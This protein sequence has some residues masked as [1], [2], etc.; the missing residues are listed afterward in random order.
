MYTIAPAGS[1]PKPTTAL[2]PACGPRGAAVRRAKCYRPSVIPQPP[3]MHGH[4]AARASAAS[5]AATPTTQPSDQAAAALLRVATLA[6]SASRSALAL[7][8]SASS[9]AMRERLSLAA[10]VVREHDVE[11]REKV[12][13]ATD[14]GRS[15]A[16]RRPSSS[17]QRRST[18]RAH[19]YV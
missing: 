7:L 18:W 1:T 5:Y 4:K 2:G 9:A 16:S 17:A 12:V 6:S 10:A 13:D 8:S 15:C 3:P 11:G 14:A 19:C